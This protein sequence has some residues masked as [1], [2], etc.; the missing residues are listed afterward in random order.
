MLTDARYSIRVLLRTPLVAAVAILSLALGI[1]GAASVFTVL[2]A[3]VLR[4]LP[5]PDPHELYTAEK[6]LV[7]GISPRYSWP[8]IEQAQRELQGRAELFAAT[9]PTQ[10]QVRLARGSDGAERSSVQLVSGGF[11]GGFRQRAQ[12]GRLIEPR[13]LA[14]S[15]QSP[16]M[17][18]SDGYWR[19]RFQRDPAVIGRELI[20]GGASLTVVGV[21]APVFFGPW[22]GFRNPDAW[23]PLTMQADIRYAFNASTDETADNTRPWPSQP[24]VE[25]LSLFARIPDASGSDAI[26]T[27]LTALHR[28]DAASRLGAADANRRADLEREVVALSS[29]GRGVSF[30]RGDLSSRLYVLLAMVGVLVAITCGNVASLLVAR[31]SARA[32]EMAVRTALGAG[33]W[34]VVRQLLVETMIVSSVGGALGLIVAA[35]GRDLLVSLFT[36]G[37]AIIDLDIRFD[38]RVLLFAVTL[39]MICGVLSGILPALRSTR[40]APTDVIKAQSRQVGD[41]GGRRGALIGKSLVAAQ[42]AFCLLLLVVAGLFIRSMQALA[43]TDVGF[44]RDRLLVA[45]MDARSIGYTDAQRQALYDRLLERL[46][47]IPGVESASLSFSGPLGTSWRQSSLIVEG[48]TPGANERPMT[49]EEFVTPDYFATVG[50][51]VIEGRDFT[52]DD[53]RPGSRSAIVNASMA[54]RFFPAGGA[55]GRR[56]TTDDVLLPDSPVIVGVVQDAKYVDVRGETPNMVYRTAGAQPV[57]VLGNIEIRASGAPAALAPTVREALSELE[58]ALPVFDIV[59]LDQRVNRGLTNDRL[60]ASLTSAFGLVALLLACLGLYGTISYGV[61]RRV[62]ELGLRMALGADRTTVAWMVVREALTLVAVGAALG[63]PLAFL[64]GRSILSLL[65]G[66]DPVDAVS[67]AQATTLLLIVAGIAAYLPARRAAQI[68]PMMALRME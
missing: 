67:Y 31:A 27:A 15:G 42:M 25:W 62:A 41:A 28:R 60:I 16:V 20:V 38:W 48:Y 29:A 66:V 5:V 9:A 56:W 46:G 64:A 54:R 45:R 59:P 23:I 22:V 33:R 4:E 65:H 7:A 68:D 24:G 19:R 36:G 6:H 55:V 49:N 13:D 51:A 57:E 3:V 37:S 39:T 30:L 63:L 12:V 2:N 21:A 50:L 26:A 47:R 11:F 17:V 58:P 35:W 8:L 61:A 14:A 18:I 43:Q 34:R 44:D 1:G 10:M 53:A 32:R 40:I 52:Q